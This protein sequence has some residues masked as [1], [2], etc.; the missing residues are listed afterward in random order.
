[1]W[2]YL[3]R[4]QQKEK[5]KTCIYLGKNILMRGKSKCQSLEMRAFLLS[6]FKEQQGGLFGQSRE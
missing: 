4:D 3:S 5:D 6:M 2:G 1:M